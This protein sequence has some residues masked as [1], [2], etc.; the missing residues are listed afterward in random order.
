MADDPR[1]PPPPG[2]APPAPDPLPGS[3]TGAGVAPVAP[4]G[5]AFAASRTGADP[6]E[7]LPPP[8]V[9]TEGLEDERGAERGDRGERGERS[10][11]DF[12]RRAVSAGV[13]AASRSKDDI[14]RAAGTEVRSW[15]EHLNLHEEITK[16]LSKMVVEVKTEI[17][18]RPNDEGRVVPET[19]N[20]VK[21]KGPPPRG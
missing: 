21:I 13:V 17:R 10:I 19:T 4:T 14:M 20:E 12:V 3:P 2:P 9:P 6:D 16:V 7:R 18:F 5:T 15:L 8:P 1:R 11:S